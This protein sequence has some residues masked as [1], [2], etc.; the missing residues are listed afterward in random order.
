MRTFREGIWFACGII[1]ILSPRYNSLR[2]KPLPRGRGVATVASKRLTP[3][4]FVAAREGI[5]RGKVRLV[6]STGM[7]TKPVLEC[8][9]G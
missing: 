2:Y 5:E 3:I 7:D 1:S 4:L 6:L 8:G 9:G